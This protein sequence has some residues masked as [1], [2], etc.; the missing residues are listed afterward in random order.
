MY[1]KKDVILKKKTFMNIIVTG[2]SKGIGYQTVKSFASEGN[3]TVIAI[4]RN[5]LKLNQLKNECFQLNPNAKVIPIGFD[6]TDKQL[7]ETLIPKLLSA[8]THIDILINNAGTLINKPFSQTS[9]EELTTVFQTNFFAVYNLIRVTLPY[10]NSNKAHIVNISSMGGFQGSAKFVGLSAYSASKAALCNLTETL[11][12][13][14][15]ETNTRV[16]CLAL[17]AVQTE[18]LAE[19]FPNYKANTSPAEM[20]DFIYQFATNADKLMNG[21]IIPVSSS[22]P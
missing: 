11:A 21:K 22:T 12:E 7:K 19:A 1:E 17:G 6:L 14:L 13:E 15:K 10:M 4:A 2:A 5:T 18:M 16:N 8:I 20:A 3:H 9:D